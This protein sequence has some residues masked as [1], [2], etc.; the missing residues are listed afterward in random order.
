MHISQFS[1]YSLRILIFLA[2]SDKDASAKKIAQSYGISF[3]HVAKAAQFLTREGYVSATRGRSGGMRLAQ[4]PS[5]ISVGEVIRKS[6][7]GNVA[8]VEC[9]KPDGRRCAIVPI[10]R[11]AGALR[12]A[13]EAFFGTLDDITLADVASNRNAL[14]SFLSA[15]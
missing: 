1:D 14:R 5:Q 9:M 7:A 3:H 8:L 2:S 11:L 12:K 15:A 6:E 13:Q 4:A 10:C